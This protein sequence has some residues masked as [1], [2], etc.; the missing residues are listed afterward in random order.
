MEISVLSVGGS[1]K[2]PT[3]IYKPVSKKDLEDHLMLIEKLKQKRQTFK[4]VEKGVEN[5]YYFNG[6]NYIISSKVVK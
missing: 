6:N 2:K 3:Q 1:K 5:K 4:I